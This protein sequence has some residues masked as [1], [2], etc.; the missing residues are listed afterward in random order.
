MKRS[1]AS[2]GA[3]IPIQCELVRTASHPIASSTI[4]EAGHSAKREL[5]GPIPP[6][7]VEH[8]IEVVRAPG[9]E[10]VGSVRRRPV[11]IGRDGPLPHRCG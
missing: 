5:A 2:A 6:V 9:L 8:A 10:E 11:E 7:D 4:R 3:R 1:P